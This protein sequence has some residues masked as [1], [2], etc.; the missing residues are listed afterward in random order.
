MNPR[1]SSSEDYPPSRPHSVSKSHTGRR[2]R[3]TDIQRPELDHIYVP[4]E[5]RSYNARDALPENI[6]ACFEYGYASDVI[7]LRG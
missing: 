5:D 6:R 1:N 7:T 4:D 3:N 2:L